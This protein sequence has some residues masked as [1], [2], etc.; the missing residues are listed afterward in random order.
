VTR[1]ET[2]EAVYHQQD[3]HALAHSEDHLKPVKPKQNVKLRLEVRDLTSQGAKSFL[4]L[5]EAGS[6]LEDAVS[7]VLK[8]LYTP[9]SEL[10]TTR[11]IATLLIALLGRELIGL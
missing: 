6:L 4:T 7:S 8:L 2:N 11:Y 9:H 10:P 5:V 3:T 1:T